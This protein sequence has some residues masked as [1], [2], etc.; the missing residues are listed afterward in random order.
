MYTQIKDEEFLDYLL[1]NGII[2]FDVFPG[3]IITVGF[4]NRSN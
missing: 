3:T 2:M 4:I 1:E